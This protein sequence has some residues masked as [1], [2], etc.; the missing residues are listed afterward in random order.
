V[1]FLCC[2]LVDLPTGDAD[3]ILSTAT[4]HWFLDHDRLFRALAGALRPGGRLVA[5]CGGAGNIARLHERAD[6][7]MHDPRFAPHFTTWQTPWNFAD[8]ST[9]CARLRAAG[10]TDRQICD[11]ALCAAL[12][13]FMSRFFDAVGAS[14]EP[15]FF[16]RD[17]AFRTA[18]TVGKRY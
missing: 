15:P 13:C 5:Q 12:R 8:P 1:S 18:L 14:P 9:T 17:E 2:D 16:D 10:F 3:A 6:R 11:I 7:V 4:F